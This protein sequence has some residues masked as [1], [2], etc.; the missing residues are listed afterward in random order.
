MFDLL[1]KKLKSWLGTDEKPDK[2]ATE[3]K[4]KSKKPVKEKKA[5]AKA[6]KKGKAPVVKATQEISILEVPTTFNPGMQKY[7]PDLEKL[8]ELEPVEPEKKGF[9]SKLAARFTTATITEAQVNELFDE[10]ELVLLENNVALEVVDA[11]RLELVANLKGKEA[12]KDQLEAKIK[13]GLKDA[14]ASVLHEPPNLIEQIKKKAGPYTIIFFGINGSG[15]TTSLAKLAHYLKKN[16]I[17]SVLAAGDTFRAASIEQ[18]ETHASRLGVPVVKHIYGSDPAAVAFDAIK[19][20]EKDHLK[21]VLIDTAGRMYTKENLIR[22]M[23]KIIRVV[24]PD[25]KIFVGE[26]IT[27]NDATEQA[28]T[29]NEAIGIDGIILTKADVDDKGGTALSVSYITK[30][31]I[32]FLGLGQAYD[33]LK[34]FKKELILKNLGL[35]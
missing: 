5:K 20:A 15:K 16:N 22:E 25:L 19:K 4:A 2:K 28:R 32:Y 26:S 21:C 8:K 7:E 33:D 3:K 6:G 30:K 34:P 35:D 24:K 31:P 1:K 27:G 9:F 18:L 12:K 10:L 17:S 29:F 14:I 11:I 23:E 13:Q